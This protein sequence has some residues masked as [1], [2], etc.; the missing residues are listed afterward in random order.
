MTYRPLAALPARLLERPDMRAALARHD[1]GTV[2]TLA[3]KY[4]GISFLKIADACDIKPERVGKV[5]RGDAAI[6]TYEKIAAVADGLRIP[7]HLI[8]LAPRAWETGTSRAA[9]PVPAEPSS[10]SDIDSILAIA[11]GTNPSTSTLLALR[12]SIEDYWRRDD[13]HG[14]EALRPAVVGQFRFVVG[15][16]DRAG[17]G[18]LRNG[19]IAVAAELARLTGWTYFDARQ[20]SQARAYFTQALR[21]AKETDDQQFVA[22]VLACMSLQATYE[23]R[24]ADALALA[25]AA[26]DQVRTAGTP[27]VMAM[28]SMREA[29]AHAALNDPGAAHTAIAQAHRQFE[30]VSATDPD[31]AWV[32]YFGE[33]KLMVDTGIVHG[34]LGEAKTAEPLIGDALARKDGTNQR[35]RAFHAFWLARTQFQRGNLD[36]A[37]RTATDA[38]EP[39]TAVA[40]ERVTGHLREFHQQLGPHLRDPVTAAFRSRL[41]EAFT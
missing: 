22:N 9:A 18:E 13:Q 36:H 38:L 37:C 30:H 35:G 6:T 28:L 19:L 10:G 15:L 7:G 29:F 20:Y 4:G 31:P 3:R 21:L 34:Q 32:A 14:G 12:S 8:G 5:A 17:H 26:Q 27:R 25:A 16:I 40:S 23:D 39:A 41:R 33:D 11:A 24:A 2:F 1:F